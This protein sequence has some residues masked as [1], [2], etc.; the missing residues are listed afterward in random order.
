[1]MKNEKQTHIDGYLINYSSG[2][3]YPTIWTNNKNTLVHRYVWEKYH[4]KIPKGYV[5][6]HKDEDK[7]NFTLENLLLLPNDEH[8]KHHAIKNKLG[9]SNKGKPKLHVSGFCGKA[10]KIIAIKGEHILQFNSISEAAK[11]LNFK[12][13]S[14]SRVLARKRKANYGWRFLYAEE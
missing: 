13:N 9:R 12:A 1:M 8:N 14:I 10:R 4:G 3:G 7:T 5:I 11:T 2:T 6:H